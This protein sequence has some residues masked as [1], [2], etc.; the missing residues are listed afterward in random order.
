MEPRTRHLPGGQGA[1]PRLRLGLLVAGLLWSLLA[2]G[3]GPVGAQGG[4]PALLVPMDNVQTD[5]CRAYGLVYRLLEKSTP[6][7]FW[8]LNYR[9]GSFLL[10]DDE[11]IIDGARQAGVAVERLSADEVG[12]ILALITEENMD[13]VPLEMAPRIGLYLPSPH[14][15]DVVA[16]VLRYAGIP[17]QV[18]YDDGILRGG[19]SAFDWIHIHHKDF[20]G[21]GH[22]QAGGDDDRELARQLGF[23]KTWMMKQRVA[24]TLREFVEGGGFV[25]AMCS[26]AETVDIALAAQGIDIVPSLFDGDAADPQANQK[27][28]YANTFAFTD[29]TVMTGALSEYSDIDVPGAGR[30]TTFSL[31][32]FSAQVDP[33]PCLLNQNHVRTLPGFDGE[34]TSFRR[35]LIKKSVVILAENN[36]GVSVRYLMGYLGKGF[37]SFYG[38]HTPGRTV[39][40]YRREAPGFRLILNNVLFPSAKVKKRK[41]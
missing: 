18:I 31:F 13:V 39:E 17:F 3:S 35:S 28:N 12:A 7:I 26:A 1:A 30:G 10:P 5:H 14:S 4:A 16:G 6:N 40:D 38:G 36:D 21:Q 29:F 24:Q 23:A 15:P 41:T 37:F 25:F 33:I 9:G 22:K 27:L 8:L 32:D 20:T 34:T 19:L 2:S 11:G